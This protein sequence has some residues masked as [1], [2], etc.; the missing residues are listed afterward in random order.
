MEESNTFMAPNITNELR[1]AR[2]VSP[3]VRAARI[4]YLICAGLFVA[5]IATQVFFAG[6]GALVQ[7]SYWSTHRSFAHVIEGIPVALL[8]IGFFSRLP[9]RMY[10]LNVLVIV[11]FTLQYIFLYA[12]PRLGLPVLRAL[13]AVNAL[14][15]FWTA[16]YLAQSAWRLIRKAATPD[17]P[18][19]THQGA[20]V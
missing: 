4:V 3:L 2:R 5:G 10:A 8:I 9:W 17:V 6:A 13:H 12:L 1:S 19:I 16:V 18:P 20:N 11:L 7:P 14:V 15:L